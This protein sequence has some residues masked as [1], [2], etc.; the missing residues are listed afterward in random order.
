MLITQKL[1]C[2]F[3]A[4]TLYVPASAADP[5]KDSPYLAKGRTEILENNNIALI[6]AASSVSFG[7]RGDKCSVN[8]RAEDKTQ[9]SNYVVIEV[10]G[11]YYS[12]NKVQ[13]SGTKLFIM[14]PG[15]KIHSVSIYKA[16]EASVGTVVFVN[17]EGNITAAP[18]KPKK[19]IEF[20]GDSITCGMGNDVDEIPC[21]QGEWYDQHNAYYSY[22]PITARALNA[23]YVLS[24]VSGIG[25]YRNWNDEH[26]TEPT[27]PDAYANLYLN[28]DA[29]KK[30]DF[31]FV[32]DVTCIAL[33]TNDFSDGDGKKVRLPFNE[34][35]YVA[36]YVAFINSVYTHAPKTQV[37]LTDSPMVKGAKSATFIKCLNRVKDE[38]NKLPGHKPVEVF[39]YSDITPHGC[40]YHPQIEDDKLMAGELTQFLKKFLK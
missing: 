32:P 39:T 19:K 22:A 29:S 35:A 40:G 4:A 9:H 38:V 11:Q 7:F 28:K 27:M 8:V 20:I 30:Y 36:A 18:N 2:F 12:R 21:G 26:K 5:V 1:A 14:L 10:D 37:V 24:S 33:G 3:I 6:G 16:T 15:N 25:I 31:G 34:D 13:P 23:D 17:A